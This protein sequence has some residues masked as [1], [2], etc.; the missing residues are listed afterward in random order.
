MEVSGQLHAPA[1]LHP[2]KSLWYSEWTPELV[3][4]QWSRQKNM[5]YL[6]GIEPRL[7]SPLLY[8]LGYPGSIKY[9]HVSKACY[10]QNKN[11]RVKLLL[12]IH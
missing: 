6:L 3:L 2:V 10:L 4:I 12:S 5:L 9:V 11:P 7:P 1:A 8:Q